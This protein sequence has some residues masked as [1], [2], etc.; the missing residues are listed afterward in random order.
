MLI[1]SSGSPKEYIDTEDSLFESLAKLRITYATRHKDSQVEMAGLGN[2]I[3]KGTSYPSHPGTSSSSAPVP[4]YQGHRLKNQPIRVCF[5][6]V[7]NRST[8]RKPTLATKDESQSSKVDDRV[9]RWHAI[10]VLNTR[11]T[12]LFTT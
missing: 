6:G 10:G 1:T 5:A 7:G 11:Q 9:Y 8:R 4:F 3:P 2:H 12:N